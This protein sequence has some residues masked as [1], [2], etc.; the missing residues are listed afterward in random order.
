AAVRVAATTIGAARRA[1]AAP[2][3]RPKLRRVDASSMRL[4]VPAPRLPTV[5]LAGTAVRRAR[6]SGLLVHA[7]LARA[8]RRRLLLRYV[9]D[10][11]WREVP[12]RALARDVFRIAVLDQLQGASVD[13]DG[14]SVVV[15]THAGRASTAVRRGVYW[16]HSGAGCGVVPIAS[17]APELGSLR[18]GDDGVY[19]FDA[20]SALQDR[21]GELVR[22]AVVPASTDE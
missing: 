3:V 19:R 12:P 18:V 15:R 1:R 20:L 17:R 8:P 9:A 13:D 21:Y 16:D 2:R 14:E 5:P 11:A 10:G 7:A 22:E 4:P 6:I